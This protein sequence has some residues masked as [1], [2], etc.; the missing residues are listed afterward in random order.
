MV[1]IADEGA[2]AEDV[3]DGRNIEEAPRIVHA[4]R[5]AV[6]LATHHAIEHVAFVADDEVC[7]LCP[8]RF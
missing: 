7:R 2:R 4:L 1:H 6:H 8:P 5:A 3:L